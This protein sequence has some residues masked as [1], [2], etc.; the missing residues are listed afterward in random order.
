MDAN[1][2]N[3][4][5]RMVESLQSKW[6]EAT[7]QCSNYKL[8]R[9]LV[10]PEE[11][12]I[13]NGFYQ[14]ES[15][16]YGSLPEFFLVLF[17]PFE[18]SEEAFSR[19]LISDWTE[20]WK[21][22]KFVEQSGVKWNPEQWLKK[23]EN[24]SQPER[25]LAEMLIDFQTQI[26][27]KTQTLVLGLIPR[28]VGDFGIFNS[29]IINMIKQLP[30]EIKLSLTDHTGKNYLKESF[31]YFKDE[32]LTIECPDMGLN[33]AIRQMATSGDAN[34]PEVNFRKC[35]YNMSDGVTAKNEKHI[36][37]WGKKA[38]RIA[39][40]TGVKSF[41][42]SAYLIYAG[43]LMHLK[44]EETDELLDS[45]IRI[46]EAAIKNEDK[47]S[48]G[49]LLQLYGYKAA[50]L[51]IKGKTSQSCQWLLKQVKLAVE[52]KQGVY[53]ISICRMA[54]R[55]AKKAGEYDYYDESLRLGYSAGEELT[56]E[57]LRISEIRIIAFYYAENLR[58]EKKMAE[59]DAISRRMQAIFGKS[60]DENIPSFS[61]KYSQSV[62]DINESIQALN[63]N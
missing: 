5:A 15:S 12:A 43:F 19:R 13:V 34:N 62:P 49:I 59:V 37:E 30:P 56:D 61:E 45:G 38:L 3:P 58:K 52:N 44:K 21:Q 35:L 24:T 41:L 2:H 8:I 42:A 26:C 14:L 1:R 11:S 47:E 16:P 22:D 4:I 50:Y 27:K 57:E 39:Q 33:K 31:K 32:A 29:W 10:Q 6:L 23:V 9:W 40:E 36:H 48:V 20:I 28:S 18:K 7:S 51:S 17:T 63:I 60:W 25:I 55:A 46:A 53:A 54:A